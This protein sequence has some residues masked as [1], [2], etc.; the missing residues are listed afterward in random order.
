MKKLLLTLLLLVIFSNSAF[1]ACSAKKIARLETRYARLQIRMVNKQKRR[2]SLRLKC[3]HQNSACQ[4]AKV[5]KKKIKKI[6]RKYRRVGKQLEKCKPAGDFKAVIEA[7]RSSGSVPLALL[8]KGYNSTPRSEI[9]LYSWDFGD[10]S[11]EFVGFNAAHVYEKAGTY[12]VTLKVQNANNLA[13]TTTTVTVTEMSGTSYYVDSETGNDANTGA[14]TTAAWKTISKAFAALNGNSIIQAGDEV[15]L[16][17]GQTFE[18]SERYSFSSTHGPVNFKP[19]GESTAALPII[20]Y[21]GTQIDEPLLSIF[22]DNSDIRF[23]ELEFDGSGPGIS[24]SEGSYL[25][26]QSS[27]DSVYDVLYLRNKIHHFSTTWVFS[28]I[29]LDRFFAFDNE[30]SDFFGAGMYFA[31]DPHMSISL[32]GNKLHRFGNHLAYLESIT[33]S[34][35]T[36]ND[37]G[38]QAFGRHFR[39]CT[40]AGSNFT[41]RRNIFHGWIDPIT[42]GS[43]HGD[44][45]RYNWAMI[46]FGPNDGGDKRSEYIDFS[47][48]II[49]DVETGILLGGGLNH[50]TISNNLFLSKNASQWGGSALISFYNHVGSGSRGNRNV[51]ILNNT[52]VYKGG[53]A[54]LSIPNYP[55]A[56]NHK[57]V[58]FI[59]NVVYNGDE[60]VRSAL[61]ME[62]SQGLMNE[63]T[64]QHNLFYFPNSSGDLFEVDD[65]P[66]SLTQWQSTFERDLNSGT[67][68]P[69]FQNVLGDDGFFSSG[70]EDLAL[71]PGSAAID[72]GSSL[73]QIIRDFAGAPRPKGAAHDIGAY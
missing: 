26:L 50:V 41:V 16:K 20:K 55:A 66:Y 59:N 62:N 45:Q 7:S 10:G 56:E 73:P 29:N 23:I 49:Y 35:I 71:Q 34:V 27:Y 61:V 4:K 67:G 2:V 70:D 3:K 30:G 53:D 6:R 32:V 47:D 38:Y 37:W 68:D 63:L 22:R 52:F 54:A 24:G 65:T 5:L 48:N 51:N 9:A 8:F 11:A 44:G 14:S 17:R 39:I 33:D 72:T 25:Y 69:V 36:D 18:T 15:L 12:T 13:T 42:D 1:G 46:H 28:G 19:Y 21:T 57:A 58:T 40:K 64:S 43:A 60:N 31:S